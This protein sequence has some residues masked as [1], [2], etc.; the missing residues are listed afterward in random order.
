MTKTR[1]IAA[2]SLAVLLCICG[3]AQSTSGSL[4]GTVVDSSGAA[5]PA[6]SVELKNPNSG[7]TRTTTSGAEGIFRFNSLEPARYE[8]TILEEWTSRCLDDHARKLQGNLLVG[9]SS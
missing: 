4:V 3:F 5:V 2:F 9:R 8:I 1:I 6:V 7:F